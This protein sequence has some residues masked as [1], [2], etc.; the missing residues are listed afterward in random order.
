[1]P[2]SSLIVRTRLADAAPIGRV[3]EAMEAVVSW[4]ARGP[5]LVVLTETR[6]PQDDA[7]LWETIERVDGVAAVELVYHNFED[8]KGESA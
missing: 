3:L 4:E 6:S 2:I 8:W 5:D 1:M 7:T